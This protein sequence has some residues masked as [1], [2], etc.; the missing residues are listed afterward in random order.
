MVGDV[1]VERLK[2]G[3]LLRTETIKDTG[4]LQIVRDIEYND[5]PKTIYTAG[6]RIHIGKEK[7]NK[8]YF[9]TMFLP[10]YNQD[11]VIRETKDIERGVGILAGEDLPKPKYGA[12]LTGLGSFHSD[13]GCP[14]ACDF[15][16]FSS[17]VNKGKTII[18]ISPEQQTIT[19]NE[20]IEGLERTIKEIFQQPEFDGYVPEY[21]KTAPKQYGWGMLL[22]GEAG[23]LKKDRLKDIIVATGKDKRIS[24]MRISTTA[25][26]LR[27]DLP[28]QEHDFMNALIE[29]RKEIRAIRG[30]EC[31]VNSQ[32]SVHTTNQD[33]REKIVL[34]EKQR[35]TL[36]LLGLKEISSEAVR[37]YNDADIHRRLS[38]AFVVQKDSEIDI[39]YLKDIFQGNT[40]KIAISLR[41]IITS[42][43]DAKMPK[44]ELRKL[45]TD[46]INAGFMVITMPGSDGNVEQTNTVARELQEDTSTAINETL[47]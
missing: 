45:I 41:P 17:E 5:E 40:D 4:D 28:I 1:K 13:E 12:S 46:L 25:P 43:E 19:I 6:F 36:T 18:P 11:I 34:T 3:H 30:D 16:T 27:K 24:T 20:S 10:S 9:R 22:S 2:N 26:V 15:C 31:T 47:Q 42:A 37:F 44:E 32:Y 23:L 39:N 14:L 7:S 29:G 21:F 38:L 33:L 35:G 8:R